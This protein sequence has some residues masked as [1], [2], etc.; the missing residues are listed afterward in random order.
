VK[1]CERI[2]PKPGYHTGRPCPHDGIVERSGGRWYCKAHDPLSDAR[3]RR[4][5]AADARF[6]AKMS[7]M[8]EADWKRQRAFKAL[9]VQPALVAALREC[10]EALQGLDASED[11]IKRAEAALDQADA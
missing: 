9:E 1:C 7:A 4:R 10:V 11:Y 8:T 6:Q 2:A 5:E 3:T